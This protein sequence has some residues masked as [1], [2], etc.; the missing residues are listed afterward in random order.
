MTGSRLKGRSTLILVA[1]AFLGP[2]VLALIL[3]KTDSSL[4]P[5]T[6]TEHGVLIVPP[7]ALPKLAMTPDAQSGLLRG[8]WSLLYIGPAECGDPCRQSLLETRQVRRAL[9]KEMGRVQRIFFI[10]Q[11]QPDESSLNREHPDMIVFDLQQQSGKELLEAVGDV[12]EGDILLLD[13]LGNLMM[14]YASGTGMK[15]MHEDLKRLLKI[16][17]IG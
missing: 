8:K 5:S 4:I 6:T 15:G 1:A 12:S 10:T 7:R 3:F 11:G 17:Q 16:S 13:P 9:G 2:F 14:R